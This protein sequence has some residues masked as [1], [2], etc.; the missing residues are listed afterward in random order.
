MLEILQKVGSIQQCSVSPQPFSTRNPLTFVYFY[1]DLDL[2]KVVAW[3]SGWQQNF[4][5]QSNMFVICMSHTHTNW[6][7]LKKNKPLNLILIWLQL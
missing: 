1:N 4:H 3:P 6:A 2:T 7:R 5:F